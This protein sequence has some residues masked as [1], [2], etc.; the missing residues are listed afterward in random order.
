MTSVVIPSPAEI[1][2]G[3]DLVSGGACD[4]ASS[5]VQ[6]FVSSPTIAETGLNMLASQI[7]VLEQLVAKLRGVGVGIEHVH[8]TLAATTQLEWH[9]PAGQVFREAVSHRQ[10]HAAALRE[11]ANQTAT[12]ASQGIDELRAMIASLQTLLAAA[13]STVGA[14][15]GTAVA[16]MCS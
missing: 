7:E 1:G 4:M 5:A 13:R 3:I 12:L 9:S 2:A 6:Q 14:T 8:D 15:A 10:Q 11:T 16:R